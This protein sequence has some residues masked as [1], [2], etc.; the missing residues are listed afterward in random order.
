[1]KKRVLLISPIPSHPQTA[2]NRARIYNLALSIKKFGHELYFA[3]VER[4]FGDTAAMKEC[5]GNDFHFTISYARPNKLSSRI[6]RKVNTFFDKESKYI[7]FIDDWYDDSIGNYFKKLY[8]KYRFD[9][10]IVE[11]A[12]FSKALTCFPKHVL[13]IVDTH[14]VLTDRH[15]IY[16]RNDKKYNWFSTTKSQ[17]KKGLKRADIIISIQDKEK[18]FFSRLT[19][20]YTVTIG[21]T[22][23]IQPSKTN[24]IKGRN[25]LFIGSANQSNID[26]FHLFYDKIFPKIRQII[27]EAALVVAGPICRILN[28]DMEGIVNKGPG[29]DLDTIYECADIVIN[30][31][32][33]G[34]GL[35]IKNIE[36]LG[37]A[38]PLVTTSIGAEGIESGADKAFLVADDPEN[39]SNAVIKILQDSLVYR[40]LC[41][42]GNRFAV[43][44]NQ[45]QMSTLDRI[46]NMTTTSL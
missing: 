3:H 4:E 27:R 46:L 19:D 41:I 17:E 40:N 36:A 11:Y 16:L 43:E 32:R 5:W 2:G 28:D 44:W 14:D 34:T 9:I 21:H 15:K 39:F 33:F 42:N 23:K 37:Y 22:V 20:K 45:N 29:V 1:M 8:R 26:A 25:I 35:K 12:F 6:R 38:K 30:P 24:K 10:V 13:K 18:D 31:I 7:F